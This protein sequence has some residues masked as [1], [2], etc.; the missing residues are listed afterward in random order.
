MSRQRVLTGAIV[1]ALAAS[2]VSLTTN[3]DAAVVKHHLVHHVAARHNIEH[4]HVVR[5][6]VR[7]GA[8]IGGLNDDDWVADNGWIGGYYDGYG[9][10]SRYGDDY[11][12]TI[13]WTLEQC[14][15]H[16]P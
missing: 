6:Y 4:R 11:C 2:A 13:E 15:P 12:G 5:R 10:Y 9:D 8:P 14:G 1:L 16:G 3:A 7:T